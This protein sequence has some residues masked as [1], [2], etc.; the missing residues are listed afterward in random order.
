MKAVFSFS[1]AVG[2]LLVTVL[3]WQLGGTIRDLQTLRADFSTH[4][5][6]HVADAESLRHLIARVDQRDARIHAMQLQLDAIR[7][8]LQAT[9]VPDDS[10][11]RA[12]TAALRGQLRSLEQLGCWKWGEAPRGVQP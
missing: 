5:S 4:Q 7:L 3:L 12:E 6:N 11:W 1:F 10:R 2:L 8:A 9:P